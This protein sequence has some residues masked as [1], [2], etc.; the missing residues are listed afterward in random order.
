MYA[1]R[2]SWGVVGVLFGLGIAT[3]VA[4]A[5]L[6]VE[7]NGPVVG[8]ATTTQRRLARIAVKAEQA[9]HRAGPG[10]L[11]EVQP[12]KL[13]NLTANSLQ[14]D[15]LP[16]FSQNGRRIAFVSK[17]SGRDRIWSMDI[18]GTNL[19]QITTGTGLYEDSYPAMS[20][21]GQF[22]AYASN[23]FGT[24][25]LFLR[26]IE[27]GTEQRLTFWN[28]SHEIEPA[29][30]PLGND[31]AFSSN[32]QD[33][34]GRYHI[35]LIGTHTGNARRLTDTVF[36]ER[37]P[38]WNPIFTQFIAYTGTEPHGDRNVWMSEI[39][40]PI[41]YQ[42]VFDLAH[43]FDPTWDPLG[44]SICFASDRGG[45]NDLWLLDVFDYFTLYYYG[46]LVVTPE[47]PLT[48]PAS[49]GF[50]HWLPRP[51]NDVDPSWRPLK[52]LFIWDDFW[53]TESHYPRIAFTSDQAGNNDIWLLAPEDLTPPNLNYDADES[54]L[55]R[56][57]PQQSHPGETVKITAAV[58]DNESGVDHVFAAI[59]SADSPVYLTILLPNVLEGR[60][61]LIAEIKE[62][63]DYLMID[64][65][66]GKPYNQVAPYDP[67]SLVYGPHYPPPSSPYGWTYYE[68]YLDRTMLA[69]LEFISHCLE[70]VD[71][72]GLSGSGDE[73][74]GDGVYTALWRI[75]TASD[76]LDYDP[77]CDYY[78]DIIAWDQAGNLHSGSQYWGE[79]LVPHQPDDDL[80]PKAYFSV[81]RHYSLPGQTITFD[82]ECDLVGPGV[83]PC[84]MGSFDPSSLRHRCQNVEGECEECEY[85]L[86]FPGGLIAAYRWDFGDGSSI[87]QDATDADFLAPIVTHAYTEPG[88]YNATLTVWD[89]GG[90]SD[91]S[92][93][94]ITVVAE[95][96]E[97]PDNLPPVA[98]F[99]QDIHNPQFDESPD[100]PCDNLVI[101]DGASSYDEDGDEI[102]MY[103]W[104]FDGY[105]PYYLYFPGMPDYVETPEDALDGAFDGIYNPFGM[106]PDQ[107]FVYINPDPDN[108][109][110]MIWVATLTVTDARG[111]QDSFS[112]WIYVGD[113]S[114]YQDEPIDYIEYDSYGFDHVAG[115]TAREFAAG[116]P[117]NWLLVND[118]GCGQKF[119]TY[120]DS[121]A[122][123]RNWPTA[124]VAEDY[125]TADAFVVS[126]HE[127]PEDPDSL[128]L[129]RCRFRVFNDHYHLGYL[130][131]YTYYYDKQTPRAIAN[132]IWMWGGASYWLGVSDPEPYDE[133]RVLCRGPI[134]LTILEDYLPYEVVW[135]DTAP[136]Q[137]RRVLHAP[138]GVI[139][140]SPYSGDLRV[141]RGT[142]TDPESWER[143]MAFLDQGGRL[144]MHG[145]DIAWAMTKDGQQSNTLL[146]NYFK[147]IF[148][149]NDAYDRITAASDNGRYRLIGQL[150][151]GWS[152]TDSFWEN[153]GPS[154]C[155]P[156]AKFENQPGTDEL[157]TAGALY[158]PP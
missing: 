137:G 30:S 4:P 142:I 132:Y 114:A 35:W 126:Q 156:N 86:V 5:A 1:N 155:A 83:W 133:W 39:G 65:K 53:S 18:D 138:K 23:R 51:A 78:V 88:I 89:G 85:E 122:Y 16:S 8:R 76:S 145:Q 29:W 37:H 71:D 108:P 67:A 68:Q 134:D 41:R 54:P 124:Y 50:Q 146:N 139:W 97:I 42:L 43:D 46:E 109:W 25:D 27:R 129:P 116:G 101:F 69:R 119:R 52:Y 82:A 14:D 66:T 100:D 70:L 31:L 62:P 55:V 91:V 64:A 148:A 136:G 90:L 73:V 11:A 26:D 150:V 95:A 21:G 47:D 127:Y 110:H 15:R 113:L 44:M 118:Y 57:T 147:V 153:H 92:S 131:D 28:D 77:A 123:Y 19:R 10:V 81:D 105:Y 33:P 40:S 22:V 135:E 140:A 61:D 20:P 60:D 49:N 63:A 6:L 12:V 96:S 74:A 144:F 128:Y 130:G 38:A 121:S 36:E 154:V 72:G 158:S 17:R 120:L 84:V 13:I 58:S 102:V 143:L 149:E 98:C 9:L 125:W 111:E 48:N 87:Y 103:E 107:R 7:E 3:S 117:H 34:W 75:P 99:T 45:N 106:P 151:N 141:Q 59:K 56:V 112:D 152:I 2:L 32:R 157:W 115:F 24:W 79:W 93:E 94:E 80:P 104:D